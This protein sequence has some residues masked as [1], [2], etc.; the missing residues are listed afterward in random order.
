MVD[1]Q[2]IGRTNQC[3][4]FHGLLTEPTVDTLPM[5]AGTQAMQLNIKS[6]EAHKL[7]TEL[8]KLTGETMTFTVTQALRECLARQ[9]RRRNAGDV[10]ARLMEIG[11]RYAAL[12][13]AGSGPDEILGYD[14]HDSSK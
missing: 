12:P 10:V 6:D 13:D 14:E 5:V 2:T 1:Q 3:T 7:A 9:R 4:A 8:A 11:S